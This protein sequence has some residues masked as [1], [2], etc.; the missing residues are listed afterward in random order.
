MASQTPLSHRGRYHRA[1]KELTDLRK[2][3]D[4]TFFRAR[5]MEE[6]DREEPQWRKRHPQP[7]PEQ[8]KRQPAAASNGASDSHSSGDNTQPI[9]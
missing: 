3:S 9:E 2:N 4:Q 5:S 8:P 1:M 7:S 6:R